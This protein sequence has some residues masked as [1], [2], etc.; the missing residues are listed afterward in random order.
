VS[1]FVSDPLQEERLENS[2]LSEVIHLI[3]EPTVRQG[4]PVSA[5]LRPINVYPFGWIHQWIILGFLYPLEYDAASL[6]N[7]LL[8]IGEWS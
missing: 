1:R 2:S 8:E 6:T 5:S 3:P 4:L 7:M